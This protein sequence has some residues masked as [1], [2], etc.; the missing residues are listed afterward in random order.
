MLHI[1]E[2]RFCIAIYHNRRSPELFQHSVINA[3]IAVREGVLASE[4]VFYAFQKGQC[5]KNQLFLMI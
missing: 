1:I 5:V 4:P 2:E 3:A